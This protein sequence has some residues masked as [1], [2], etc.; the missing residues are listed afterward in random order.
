MLKY[1]LP[2]LLFIVTLVLALSFDTKR[3]ELKFIVPVGWP[4]P[5]YDVSKNKPT[6]DGFKLGRK[7]FFDSVLSRDGSV[8][9]A[10]CHV[11]N[12]GFT[13]SGHGLSKGMNGLKGKRNSLPLF[14][15]AWNTSFMWDG[16]VNNIEVQPL[17]PITNPAEMNNTLDNI[18]KKLSASPAYK[19]K[20]YLAF[21]DSAITGQR[22]LKAMSQFM[23][24]FESFNS[25]YDKY[26]RHE[27]GGAMTAQE[28]NGLKLFRTHC[29]TCHTEPLFTNNSFRNIGLAP[30]PKLNDMGRMGITGDTRD[31]LKFKVPSLR[32]VAETYPY[33][34]DGR[35]TTLMQVL[36]HYTSGVVQSPSLA[37]EL[38]KNIILSADDKN[39]LIAFM[40][41]LTDKEFLSDP[42]FKE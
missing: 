42:R 15:L 4:K 7:L 31:S 40:Q 17:A 14:N 39:D 34:H 5:V 20:F 8:S 27:Q 2:C 32:N 18:V 21:G 41:T 29:E 36:D 10:S 38:Q 33:M 23:V 13:H 9:C 19:T 24:M 12:A 25:R 28:L 1:A 30:D 3:D 16:G 22:V 11:Q 6:S 37:K 35:F 26:I